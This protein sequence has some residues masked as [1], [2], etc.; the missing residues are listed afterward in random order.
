MDAYTYKSAHSCKHCQ[1]IVLRRRN[2]EVEGCKIRLPHTPLEI[3]QAAK[4]G[5]EFIRLFFAGWSQ[6]ECNSRSHLFSKIWREPRV[7]NEVHGKVRSQFSRSCSV[8]KLCLWAGSFNIII[9]TLPKDYVNDPYSKLTLL[10]NARLP[11]YHVVERQSDF[12]LALEYDRT[13]TWCPEI[14]VKVS[15]GTVDGD[16]LLDH[17]ADIAYVA[18]L[19]LSNRVKVAQNPFVGSERSLQQAREWLKTCHHTHPQCSRAAYDFVPTRLLRLTPSNG[20]STVHLVDNF[21][22]QFVEWA[23]LTYVWGGDQVFK[24]TVASMA[25]MTRGIS[26]AD[27]PRTLQDAIRVCRGLEVQYLWVDCLCIVQD[28]EDDL[29]R[30]L[31]IMPYIYQR[32]WVTIS[33]STA[34]AVNEGFMQDRGYETLG[35]S[36]PISLPYLSTDGISTG[37]IIL[38][39]IQPD[40]ISE[41]VVQDKSPI[42]RRAWTY[43]ERRL[44][45]RVLDFNER[46]LTFLCRTGKYSEGDGPTLWSC[47]GDDSWQQQQRNIPC[48]QDQDQPVPAW[49]AIVEDY[50]KRELTFPDDRLKAIAALADLYRLR[51]GQTYVAGLW[52]ETLV[53]DLGWLIQSSK[54]SRSYELLPRPAE[55]RAPSWS[56]A[57][58]NLAESMD[59]HF[60]SE[61]VISNGHWNAVSG[62]H[63]WTAVATI[64]DVKLLQNPPHTTYGQI[65]AGYIILEGLTLSTKWLYNQEIYGLQWEGHRYVIPSRYALEQEWSH[66]VDAHAI[67]TALILMQ[68]TSTAPGGDMVLFGLLLLEGSDK[69]HRRVGTFSTSV[70]RNQDSQTTHH[71]IPGID[72]RFKRQTLTLV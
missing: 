65:H 7:G 23:A 36:V 63:K 57:A 56:W 8:V 37:A 4:D 33:A 52:K 48:S 64:V 13:R 50:I 15:P 26:I 19:E 58:I 1:R 72:K 29:T 45:P 42:H 47:P 16:R 59:F 46:N 54:Q 27:L 43:Q 69:S 41:R 39:E 18:T 6:A 38:A 44:S 21:P 30:E 55:Y 12:V 14:S 67:V 32:A 68:G 20:S 11:Q 9:S 25:A 53:Y 17:L 2:F 40:H 35:S 62:D 28:D 49:H 31:A 34:E 61:P 10:A 66:E 71:E 51:T 24:T 70:P 3:R 22:G 60:V 5:C